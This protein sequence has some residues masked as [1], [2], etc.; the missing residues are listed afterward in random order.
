[1]SSPES[2]PGYEKEDLEIKTPE[3]LE[4]AKEIAGV[5]SFEIQRLNR[6]INLALE[7][8]DAILLKNI[9]E[10]KVLDYANRKK[11][12]A[13]YE[14]AVGLL[15]LEPK[16][17]LEE[18]KVMADKQKQAIEKIPEPE[19]E[20]TESVPYFGLELKFSEEELKEIE[21]I[22]PK[23]L[24]ELQALEENF[25]PLLIKEISRLVE[26]EK[27]LFNNTPEIRDVKETELPDYGF[28]NYRGKIDIQGKEMTFDNAEY[29]YW[30]HWTIKDANTLKGWT[31][32]L[33]DLKDKD[34]PR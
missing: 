28:S 10:S 34:D 29:L 7:E 26:L 8:G 9:L 1:M 13:L 18:V 24:E 22:T 4:E 30:Y 20:K 15:K 2:Y 14:W 3:E 6:Q 31:L 5:E 23:T 32:E 11:D 33:I 21:K 17:I 25:P 16:K 19:K 27:D 12:R